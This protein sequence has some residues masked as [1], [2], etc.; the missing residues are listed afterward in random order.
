MYYQCMHGQENELIFSKE[1]ETLFIMIPVCIDE[2]D[3]VS[4]DKNSTQYVVVSK[5]QHKHF[6]TRVKEGNFSYSLEAIYCCNMEK[7]KKY[8]EE[9]FNKIAVD[10]EESGK[11]DYGVEDDFTYAYIIAHTEPEKHKFLRF[12]RWDK[13]NKSNGFTDLGDNW[14][15]ILQLP[16]EIKTN[17][18]EYY[19]IPTCIGDLTDD[20]NPEWHIFS[21]IYKIYNQKTQLIMYHDNLNADRKIIYQKIS[22]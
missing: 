13:N 6:L 20:K 17:T 18:L 7:F 21:V 4:I 9:V 16:Q 19:R 10:A 14:R 3:C 8:T 5:E 22:K 12:Y 11:K 1:N 15:Q 2:S